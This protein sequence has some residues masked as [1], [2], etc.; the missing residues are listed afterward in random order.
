MAMQLKTRR[1]PEER[2][3]LQAQTRS[4][5][6]EREEVGRRVGQLQDQ[7]MLVAEQRVIR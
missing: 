6:L 7:G 4:D 5:W 1:V 3:Q 2:E